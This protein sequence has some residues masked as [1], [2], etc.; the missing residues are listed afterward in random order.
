MEP[1][2]YAIMPGTD[3]VVILGLSTMNDL[4]VNPYTRLLDVMRP[5]MT[6]P[7]PNV[8]TPAYLGSRRVSL[9]VNAFQEEGGQVTEEHD[10]AVERLGERGPEMFMDPAD[11]VSARRVALEESVTDAVEQ[12]L[13]VSNA[14]RLRGVLHRHFNAF[15]RALRDDPPA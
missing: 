2:S 5:R 6:P 14:E 10:E 3:T 9:S 11:E 12:G 1:T 15:R 7:S 13:S 8:E 4:G